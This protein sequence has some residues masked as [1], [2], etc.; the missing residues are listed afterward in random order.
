MLRRRYPNEDGIVFNPEYCGR[1]APITTAKNS[2][3]NPIFVE[4]AASDEAEGEGPAAFVPYEKMPL[5][6]AKWPSFKSAR[7]FVVTEKIHG[8]NFVLCCAVRCDGSVRLRYAKR[9]SVLNDT[10]DFYGFRA[11]K[12]PQRYCDAA[13]ARGG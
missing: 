1:C 13:R 7:R 2:K 11:A 8:A 6:S 10:S 9:G 3:K 5:C 4:M 12:T